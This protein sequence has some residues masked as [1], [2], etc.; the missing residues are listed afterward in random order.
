MMLSRFRLVVGAFSISA[1]FAVIA[2]TIVEIKRD[3]FA[4][5]YATEARRTPDASDIASGS[6]VSPQLSD[7]AAGGKEWRPV[8][9]AIIAGGRRPTV[10]SEGQLVTVGDIMQGYELKEVREHEA[11][12]IY[13]G[14]EQTIRL[15]A[16]TP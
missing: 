5:P 7:T 1:C 11:V 13:R 16:Q 12:F 4:S 3:P 6:A 15:G 10:Y 9:Q 14:K 2:Q 8:L